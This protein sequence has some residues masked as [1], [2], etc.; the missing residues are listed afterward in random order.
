MFLA[1]VACLCGDFVV[2]VGFVGREVAIRPRQSHLR[3]GY[4]LTHRL[5]IECVQICLVI[6][7]EE[8]FS[9]NGDFNLRTTHKLD[10][11][12]LIQ[13]PSVVCP[14]LGPEQL[15]SQ[16]YTGDVVGIENGIRVP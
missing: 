10:A 7:K 13:P 15:M 14:R 4:F 2:G 5:D 6:G 12:V 3:D 9:N 11:K 16:L 8:S 1:G